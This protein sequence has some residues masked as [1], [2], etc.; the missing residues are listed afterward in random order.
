MFKDF[1]FRLTCR[2]QVDRDAPGWDLV[3]AILDRGD[4]AFLAL[5]HGAL[6][7][8]VVKFGRPLATSAS[9]CTR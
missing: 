9:T 2:C 7:P 8:T 1:C 3:A 5:A 4:D 6:R